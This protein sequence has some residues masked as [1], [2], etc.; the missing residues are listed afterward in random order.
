MCTILH[1]NDAEVIVV[2]QRLKRDYETAFPASSVPESSFP[3]SS[4]QG[5]A[6]TQAEVTE[7]TQ[8]MND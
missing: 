1:A 7:E 6:S 8:G 5:E 4:T 3:E 2:V